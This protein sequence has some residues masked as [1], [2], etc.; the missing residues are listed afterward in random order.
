MR[1]LLAFILVLASLPGVLGAT[2]G[3]AALEG[4]QAPPVVSSLVSG[5][6]V[7]V[8]FTN[9]SVEW[10]ELDQSSAETLGVRFDESGTIVEAGDGEIANASYEAKIDVQIVRDARQAENTTDYLVDAYEDGRVAYRGN[11]AWNSV[12]TGTAKTV[13]AATTVYDGVTGAMAFFS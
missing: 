4:S 11:G 7:N 9:G 13:T 2:T 12:V 3:L 1:R 8:Y 10:E 5:S 6:A